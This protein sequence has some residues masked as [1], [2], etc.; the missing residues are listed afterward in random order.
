MFYM[1]IKPVIIVVCLFVGCKFPVRNQNRSIILDSSILRVAERKYDASILD[2]IVM[3]GTNVPTIIR[4]ELSND[5]ICF[6]ESAD[7]SLSVENTSSI[8]RGNVVKEITVINDVRHKRWMIWRR[9]ENSKRE[10]YCGEYLFGKVTDGMCQELRL[11]RVKGVGV[12]LVP[13]W[14]DW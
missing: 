11:I 2:R 6:C 5:A 7:F 10:V 14:Y 12:T 3:S 9:Y 8:A 1:T 13:N 4:F